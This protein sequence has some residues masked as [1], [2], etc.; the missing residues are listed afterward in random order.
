M[1]DKLKR[2]ILET[3]IGSKETAIRLAPEGG[4]TESTPSDHD[5]ACI[6]EEQVLAINDILLKAESA[7]K[8]PI[9][10]EWAFADG[11][12]YLLQARPITTYLHLPDRMITSTGEHKRLYMNGTLIEQGIQESMSVL[13]TDFF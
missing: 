3:K 6:T 9:D 2:T 7:Y 8:K 10:I 11:Q 12:L 5:L 13:G 1:V 4:T